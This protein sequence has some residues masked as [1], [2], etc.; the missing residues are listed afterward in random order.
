MALPQ[1]PARPKTVAEY[2]AAAPKEAR[3]KLR[4]IRK[5]IRA[6]VPDAVESLKWSMPA[7]SYKRI[8]VI[9]A[10]HQHH[11]GFY[12]TPSAIRAFK[13]QLGKFNTST[14]TVQF[15]LDQPLPVSLIRRMVAFRAKES[16]ANDDKWR[17]QS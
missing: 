11:L 7:Y 4:E 14:G 13:K 10:G 17:T 12:P 5:V 16:L 15:P 1:A 6:T 9:F 3:A 2:I 8:L